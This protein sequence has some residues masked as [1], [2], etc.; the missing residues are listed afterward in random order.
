MRRLLTKPR[1]FVLSGLL[2]MFLGACLPVKP[3]VVAAPPPKPQVEAL[4]SLCRAWLDSLATWQDSDAEQTKDGI[5][6]GYRRQEDICAP[7]QKA[8]PK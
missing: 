8:G 2:T 3:V 5:D 7:Y 6:Y 4:W 1:P